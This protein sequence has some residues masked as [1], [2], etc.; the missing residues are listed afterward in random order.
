MV[1]LIESLVIIRNLTKNNAVKAVEAKVRSENDCLL[2]R[3][4]SETGEVR[5]IGRA[6]SLTSVW[7]LLWAL[8]PW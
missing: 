1:I 5:V 2:R 6:W 7:L 8:A 3:F 4:L